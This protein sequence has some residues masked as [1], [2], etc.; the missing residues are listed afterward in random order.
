VVDEQNTFKP[1]RVAHGA[2]IAK[3]CTECH[4]KGCP[5]S[6]DL[7]NCQNCH[8]IH[9]LVNPKQDATT[10][11][12]HA[13]E[14]DALVEASKAHL[15]EGEKFLRAGQWEPARTAFAAALSSNPGSERAR[16]ALKMIARRLKPDIAGFKIVGK[17]FDAPSGLPREIVMDGT[18]IG[19]LLIP[20]GSFD[21]GSDQLAGAKPVH[22]V[23]VAAFYLAKH[24]MSQA[25]WKSLMTS[26]PSYYQGGKYP[27]ADDLPV[28]QVSWDDC[29]AMVAAVN[30]RVPGGGARLP[31][32]AEWEYA[33]RA[34]ST[35][36]F[37][38]SKAISNGWLRDNSQVVPRGAAATR[39]AAQDVEVLKI[40]ASDS[41][42]PHPVGTSR[43]NPWGLYDMSGNVSEWCSSLAQ[44]YPYNETDGRESA[45]GQGL[46][47]LRGANFADSAEA[48]DPAARHSDRPSRKLRW[49]GVR[50]AF[51]P[52]EPSDPR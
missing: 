3:L 10:I 24:E 46:R 21:M 9:A 4:S 40:T 26:N 28:E 38:V 42:A 2:D 33:A 19:M 34:G 17:Q 11:E 39:T 44:P 48:A 49:N 37:D 36:A 30:Q 5:H 14:L 13:R 31:T 1:D 20:A 12:A 47:V 51:S 6:R 23:D 27:R 41:F 22:T 15:A 18:G 8:H 29:Q 25:E 16:T 32:E 50:L 35:D 43:P 52:P 7:L 45:D